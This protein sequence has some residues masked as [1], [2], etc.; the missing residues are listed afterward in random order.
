VK[1]ISDLKEI[2]SSNFRI[3]KHLKFIEQQTDETEGLEESFSEQNQDKE[4]NSASN[5]IYLASSNPKGST[6]SQKRIKQSL[7]NNNN[8]QTHIIQQNREMNC[9]TKKCACIFLITLN[10]SFDIIFNAFFVTKSFTKWPFENLFSYSR[11]AN[12]KK[13]SYEFSTSLFDVWTVSVMRDLFL[14]IVVCISGI[15][16]H[17]IYYFIK[18]I[19][20]KY[21]AAFLCL[22]MYSFAMIKMLVYADQRQIVDKQNMC[23]FIWNIIAAFCFFISFYML[24][25]LKPKECSYRKTDVD[26][27]DLGEIAGEEDIF[28]GIEISNFCCLIT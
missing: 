12:E 26:G 2:T 5:S 3:P 15:K 1:S 25:L 19:H 8:T 9:C 23:M 20:Q 6:S 14:L 27:G 18:F 10:I 16:H 17:K 28:I 22:I 24:A 13:W 21:I 4:L 7:N 11:M